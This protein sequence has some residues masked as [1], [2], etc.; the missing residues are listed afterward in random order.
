MGLSVLAPTAVASL[1]ATRRESLRALEDSSQANLAQRLARER[2]LAVFARANAEHLHGTV[3]TTLNA[4]AAAIDQAAASGNAA[5]F[6]RCLQRDDVAALVA[7]PGVGRKTAERLLVE[8]RDKSGDWLDELSPDG[9]VPADPRGAKAVD[10]D[11]RAEAE[12]A[13]VS[14]GYKLTEASRLIASIDA[15]EA[16]T[17]EELIRL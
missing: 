15:P 1:K 11:Q 14:L 17:S 13:L 7:L 16:S 2:S 6:A 12:Q 4:C 8:M 3:Q 5:D 9:A 10:A